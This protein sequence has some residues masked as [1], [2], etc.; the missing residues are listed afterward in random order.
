MKNEFGC[1]TSRWKSKDAAIKLGRAMFD[2][3]RVLDVILWSGS[4]TPFWSSYLEHLN[5]HNPMQALQWLRTMLE[6]PVFD[7]FVDGNEI[8]VAYYR[9]DV[10]EEVISCA[11]KYFQWGE[12]FYYRAPG[13]P[14]PYADGSG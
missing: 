5:P 6:L 14:D 13:T 11:R 1:D 9:T 7:R 2:E 4:D 8:S 10:D 12:N 3:P